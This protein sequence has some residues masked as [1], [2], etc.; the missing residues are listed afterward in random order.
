MKSFILTFA[1]LA[2]V[3]IAAFAQPELPVTPPNEEGPEPVPVDGGASLLLG[4]GALAGYRRL[5]KKK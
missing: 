2:T 5:T 1:L 4:A 3:S